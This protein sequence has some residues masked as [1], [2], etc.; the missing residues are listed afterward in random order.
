[1]GDEISKKKTK[2][3]EMDEILLIVLTNSN[4]ENEEEG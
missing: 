1:M 3:C 2:R 4:N